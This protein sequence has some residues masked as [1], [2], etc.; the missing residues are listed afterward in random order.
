[1]NYEQFRTKL[2]KKDTEQ[3][4]LAVGAV[5]EMNEF[6]NSSLISEI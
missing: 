1:M 3:A 6:L 4:I 2:N 5:R